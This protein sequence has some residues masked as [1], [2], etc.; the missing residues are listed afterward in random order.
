MDANN[1]DSVISIQSSNSNVRD[2]VPP[3]IPPALHSNEEVS[4]IFPSNISNFDTILTDH[5][6]LCSQNKIPN[7]QN[8]E[9]REHVKN[10]QIKGTC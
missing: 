1:N 10:N 4:F 6:G 8:G 9:K 3:R 5:I 2:A 7:K